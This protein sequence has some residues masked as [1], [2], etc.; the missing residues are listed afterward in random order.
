MWSTANHPE[1]TS[2]PEAW[3]LKHVVYGAVSIYSKSEYVGEAANGVGAE[4]N[5]RFMTVVRDEG[6]RFYATILTAQEE[7]T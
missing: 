4:R 3:R 7:R 1:E 6:R 5:E 2:F